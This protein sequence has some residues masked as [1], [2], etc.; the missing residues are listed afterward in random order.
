MI[1][2]V[3]L[4]PMLDKTMHMDSL[5]RGQIHRALK[6]EMVAG[7]KGINVARQLKSLGVSVLA[8]GFLG[9]EVGSIVEGLLRKE[10]LGH[11]FVDSGVMTREGVTYLEPNGTST[12]VFEPAGRVAVACVRALTKRIAKLVPK[13]TW[14]VCSG[15]SPCTE[16]DNVYYEAISCANKAG[17]RSVLDSYGRAFKRGLEAVP[18]MIKPNRQE[19][20]KTFG[21]ELRSEKE[22]RR[23]MENWL[24]A[25][26]KF[27][28]LTDGAK[29]AYAASS[30]GQ[31]KLQSPSITT[32]NP[33]G[34]GDAMV[35]GI[36]F[37]LEK[38]WE[39][40]RCL[41]FGV[42]AGAANAKKWT[43]AN[44]TYEEIRA[45]RKRVSVRKLK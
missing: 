35:A 5:A 18:T 25:G 44:S 32:V 9:G 13:S 21:K 39:F 43:V 28:V 12:A 34:S 11:D 23:A 14:V 42:A 6:L 36:V 40:E 33:V 4:N 10:G 20:Q 8:T 26:I 31:W 2:T 1:T 29:P 30:G 15:S 24:N 16:A 3:T 7:G 41:E 38:G 45:L 27:I 37:G 19:Y 17:I 22:V